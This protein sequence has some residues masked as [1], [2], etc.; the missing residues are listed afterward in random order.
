MARR[1]WERLLDAGLLIRVVGAG[2]FGL[3]KLGSA[4]MVKPD[5]A[6]EEIPG[7]VLLSKTMD[8]WCKQI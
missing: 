4:T 3:G 2:D 6:L 1:E 7:A 5:V 8:R